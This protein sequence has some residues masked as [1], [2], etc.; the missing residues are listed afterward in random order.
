[1]DVSEKMSSFKWKW[2]QWRSK[3]I[4]FT[5]GERPFIKAAME[6]VG[7]RTG[8][9]RAPSIRPPKHLMDE[10]PLLLDSAGVPPG[11]IGGQLAFGV[12]N[13]LESSGQKTPLVYRLNRTAD[14]H[15]GSSHLA[16]QFWPSG[17]F[18]RLRLCLPVMVMMAPY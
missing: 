16:F 14:R 5:G 8:P 7:L 9:P 1:M 6:A 17:K 15:S 11:G 13:A 4:R 18:R 2:N 3:V 12:N 10:V